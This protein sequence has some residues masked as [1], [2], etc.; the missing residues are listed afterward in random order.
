MAANPLS[1]HLQI[2]R[3][4]L[5][6]GM[7]IMHRITGIALSAGTLVLLYWL[8]AAAQ[9]M[10]S[11]EA[12]QRCIGSLPMQLVMV[13]W[14]FAFFYHLCNGVRHLAWDVGWGFDIPTAY[15]TG[16]IAIGAAVVLTVLTW[17]CVIAQGGAA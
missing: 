4:Q 6:S 1:P 2:Y 15:K 5:T 3:P 10:E 11:Y 8:V 12:A 16:Y 9:G 17:A 13:G 7:S 14:T